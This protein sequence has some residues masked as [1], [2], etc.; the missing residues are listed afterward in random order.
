M[1]TL[2][3]IRLCLQPLNRGACATLCFFNNNRICG[4]KAMKNA[5]V[6]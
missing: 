2:L 1:Q 4:A 3:V 5:I 6:G